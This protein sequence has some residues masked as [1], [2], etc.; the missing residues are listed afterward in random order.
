LT[1]PVLGRLSD[2]LGRKPLFIFACM[3]ITAPSV[4][5]LLSP[6]NLLPYLVC[7]VLRGF[8]GGP[9]GIFPLITAYLADLYP[10]EVRS[11]YFGWSFAIFSVG[12][13]LS[14]L[15][16]L[17]DRGASNETVFKVSVAF[18]LLSVLL[19]FALPES[20]ARNSRVPMKGGWRNVLPFRALN[21]LFHCKITLVLACISFFFTVCENGIETTIFYF[22]N[23]RLGFMEKD[24]ARLFLILGVSSLFVQSIAL[25]ILLKFASDSSVLRIGLV[26]Y[27]FHLLLFAWSTSKW[28]VDANM[29]L[30][31]FTFLT[32]PAINGLMSSVLSGKDQGV[33]FGTL[34]SVRGIAA[35]LGPLMFG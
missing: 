3:V 7:T 19:A 34:A 31:G 33:G 29:L 12:F 16:T 6:V 4:C 22:L 15:I 18:N 13:I 10:A 1:A 5:L 27:I 11:K 17:F 20:L 21:K 23:D 2:T 9:N 30:A 25:P 28:M 14:P 35:A 32:F 8:A 24:N 26:S